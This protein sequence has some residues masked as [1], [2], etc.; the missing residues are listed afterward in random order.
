MVILN[1]LFLGLSKIFERAPFWFLHLKSNG[2]FFITFYI[3]RYRKKVVFQNLQNAFPEKSSKELLSLAKSYYRHLCD[4]VFE[5]I[6][7]NKMSP[8]DLISRIH[9]KDE[10]QIQDLINKHPNI[11]FCGAHQGNWEWVGSYAQLAFNK[12]CFAIVKP[13][14][15]AFFENYINRIRSRFGL[16][17]IPFKQVSRFLSQIKND[18]AILIL[19]AD[20]S[21]AK[22]E[23]KQWLSFLNQET[24]FSPG[25]GKLAT[26]LGGPVIFI[27]IKKTARSYYEITPTI[28]TLN[29]NQMKSNEILEKYVSLLEESIINNPAS[30]LWSHRRWKHK[31]D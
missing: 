26:K 5:I 23:P 29:P 21:P 12:Q 17:L 13:L 8:E 3:I 22:S 19:P 10:K 30:W 6:K 18:Q 31:N 1:Y 11:L 7:S 9:F 2:L 24:A 27:E 14:S 16:K 20:Q 25:I 28:I 15:N 4:L